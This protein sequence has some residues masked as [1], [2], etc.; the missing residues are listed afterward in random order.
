MK[1]KVLCSLLFLVVVLFT[2]SCSETQRDLSDDVNPYKGYISISGAFALY[3]LTVKWAEEYQILHPDVRIDISAG[4]AGKGITDVL[5]GMVEI[6]MVSREINETEIIKGAYPIPVA[7][8][9]VVPTVNRRNTSLSLLMKNGVTK[10]MMEE[11]F[12]SGKTLSWGELTGSFSAEKVVVFTRSDACGA[13]DVWGKFVGKN[14]E[15]IK[16]IGVFGDPG[17]ADA[18]KK[19][20]SSIGYNNIIYAYNPNTRLQ[21]KE[22]TVVP[23]DLNE[24]GKI[25]K[26]EN[27]YGHLDTLM[28]AISSG[29][30]PKPP[31]RDLYFVT[32]GKPVSPVLKAFLQWIVTNGGSMARKAGF[33]ELSGELLESTKNKIK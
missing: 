21:Y 13:G 23:L 5:T 14:Q 20:E 12:I 4:G 9:A 8:D 17:M 16:G 11:I 2:I 1:F 30:Y 3:P 25:D 10:S 7:Q 27:F 19:E 15:A 28:N 18:V 31:A 33:I 29:K 6:G 22:L 26:D 24:N 32:K